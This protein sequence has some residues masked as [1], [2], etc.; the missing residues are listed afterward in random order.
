MDLTSCLATSC[1]GDVV[2]GICMVELVLERGPQSSFTR[3]YLATAVGRPVVLQVC[4]H[5]AVAQICAT[6][7][8]FCGCDSEDNRFLYSFDFLAEISITITVN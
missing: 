6:D 8:Q 2:A 4:Q 3:R 5:S 1:L 7:C